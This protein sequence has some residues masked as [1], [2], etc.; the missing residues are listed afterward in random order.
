MNRIM[1]RVSGLA[2]FVAVMFGIAPAASSY[3][4]G[5]HERYLHCPYQSENSYTRE[6]YITIDKEADVKSCTLTNSC[7]RPQ[8]LVVGCNSKVTWQNDDADTHLI[9]S[10]SRDDGPKGWFAST[11]L[12]PGH[13]YSY[14]FE[15]PGI[16]GYYDPTHSWAEGTVI[17]RSGNNDTDSE[18]IKFVNGPNCTLGE[19]NCAH[20]NLK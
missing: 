19:P 3:M 2:I 14:V 4:A 10:G 1:V 13:A 17:V 6:F 18:W 11:I 16:Y 9:T 20:P 5:T 7:Y 8:V 15:R 12:N